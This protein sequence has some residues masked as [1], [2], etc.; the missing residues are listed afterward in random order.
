MV[1]SRRIGHFEPHDNLA[2]DDHAGSLG[3]AIGEI[4]TACNYQLIFRALR[5]GRAVNFDLQAAIIA[6]EAFLQGFASAA[7]V[8]PQQAGGDIASMRA[9]NAIEKMR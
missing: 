4:G 6:T 3:L 5:V 9:I 8:N 7:G 2:F 1:T